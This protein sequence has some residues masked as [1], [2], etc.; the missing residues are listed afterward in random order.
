MAA[1]TDCLSGF[2]DELERDPKTL[3]RRILRFLAVDDSDAVIPATVGV[4][5]NPGRDSIMPATIRNYLVELHRAQLLE[6]HARFDNSWTLSWIGSLHREI[7]P[8]P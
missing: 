1:P 2:F 7:E 5:R 6:L 4:P 8:P 3:F